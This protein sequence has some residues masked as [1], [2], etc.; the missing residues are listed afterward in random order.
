MEQ[1]ELN[2]WSLLWTEKKCGGITSSSCIFE[3]VVL[4]LGIRNSSEA[5]LCCV[6]GHS[7]LSI[8][9]DPLAIRFLCDLGPEE[10]ILEC[11]PQLMHLLG[12]KIGCVFVFIIHIRTRI[13]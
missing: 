2:M 4:G 10:Y 9:H 3:Y 13:I 1:R 5:L 8:L 6:N 7:I 12:L 11:L